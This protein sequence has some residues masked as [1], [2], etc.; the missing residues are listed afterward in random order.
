MSREVLRLERFLAGPSCWATV[1]AVLVR[2]D[3]GALDARTLQRADRVLAAEYPDTEEHADVSRQPSVASRLCALAELFLEAIDAGWGPCRVER[4]RGDSTRLVWPC[5][6][7]VLAEV[8]TKGLDRLVRQCGADGHGDS[9]EALLGDLLALWEESPEQALLVRA[10][11]RR[12]VPIAWPAAGGAGL[13]LGQGAR[14]QLYFASDL[15][16]PAGARELSH[17]KLA[18]AALLEA[19]GLPTTRPRPVADAAAAVAEAER[20]GYP[21][22]LKPNRAWAQVGVFTDLRDA[23][24]VE[25]AYRRCVEMAGLQATP[26]LVERHHP[27]QYVRATLVGERL[28]AVLTTTAPLAEADGVRTAEQLARDRYGFTGHGPLHERTAA[29][30]E[31]VLAPQGLGLGDVPAVGRVVRVGHQSHGDRLD[32]TARVHP[33]LRRLLRLVAALLPLPMT[34]VDLLMDDPVGP[35]DSGRDV[36]LEVNSAPAFALHADPDR[37]SPRDLSGMIVGHLFPRGWRSACVPVVA[38]PSGGGQALD[39]LADEA[40]RRGRR[41]AGYTNGALWSGSPSNRIAQGPESAQLLPLDHRAELLFLEVDQ[42]LAQERGLPVP[43]VDH[44]VPVRDASP[45]NRRLLSRLRRRRPLEPDL[46]NGLQGLTP[47]KAT[48]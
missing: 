7:E 47:W 5:P 23:H 32:I 40:R 2:F 48:I 26:V 43:R 44:V 45:E 6:W 36:V 1:P 25:G 27:G 39:S 34:G 35:F 18:T 21:V 12:R 30:L 8:L 15:A 41:P 46:L 10:A 13:V 24:A 42:A 19:A 37:G 14:R 33:S 9:V 38:A 16:D 29:M 4:G 28:G 22:V 11:R 3:P 31:A 17:D 20:V